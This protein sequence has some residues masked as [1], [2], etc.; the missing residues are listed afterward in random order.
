MS[1]RFDG[2]RGE[3]ADPD[4]VCEP[5]DVDYAEAV[6]IWNAAVTRRPSV[7]V[8]CRSE[9]DVSIALGYAQREGLEVSVRGGG[10]NYA[11]F[12]LTEGGLM[13]DL[14]PMK[15]IALDPAARRVRCGGGT[16]WGELDAATQEH[17]LAVTGGFIS[18]T[19]VAGLTLG[20]GIGWLVRP[21][22]LTCQSL[23][24]ARVVLADGR[25]M[26]ASESENTDL[27][28]ALR[29]GGGNFGVVT[30]FEFAL[31]PGFVPIF[32]LGGSYASAD[33][34]STAFGGVPDI[35]YVINIS[36]STPDPAGL[37]AEREWVR[38]YWSALLPHATG[39]GSYVNFLPEQD[40]ERVRNAYGAK[41]G[42][43]QAIKSAYDP[44][45]VFHLNANIRPA[46][47]S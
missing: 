34:D 46:Q 25:V 12:A 38:E 11:G 17:A 45:N 33:P 14:T 43:L 42:R 19:G 31:H 18:K 8:R 15:S 13:I 29:G 9:A 26:W 3:F 35:G 28:W 32:P 30:E 16:T 20:G 40:E 6:N 39:V 24:G 47:P 22:G 4:V 10:H 27:F 1:Y 36:G 7:V 41:Y 5:G 23:V 21:A 44:D 2:L 37:A